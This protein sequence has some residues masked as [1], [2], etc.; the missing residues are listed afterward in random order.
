MPVKPF[1]PILAVISKASG[2]STSPLHF[3]FVVITFPLNLFNVNPEE[4]TT[5]V[6]LS[7]V[8]TPFQSL[9]KNSCEVIH[10]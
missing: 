7:H 9:G 8:A 4:E 5:I 6:G 10:I 2:S 3:I 1:S